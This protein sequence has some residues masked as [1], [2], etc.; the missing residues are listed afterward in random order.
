MPRGRHDHR[1]RDPTT[2]ARP[3][4]RRLGAGHT[5]LPR[6]LGALRPGLLLPGTRAHRRCRGGSP[7]HVGAVL[8]RVRRCLLQVRPARGPRDHGPPQRCPTP[9]YRRVPLLGHARCLM[10]LLALEARQNSFYYKSRYQQIVD[11][12]AD[13]MVLN[14]VGTGD[15]WPADR[16]RVAGSTHIDDLIAHA[17]AWHAEEHF[18][19]VLTFSESAV[20]A[21]ATV[22]AAL[23][24]PGIGVD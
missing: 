10:K 20:I 22:A 19:G 13:L 4:D 12:G 23:G 2:V 5:R 18:D 3:P 7:E 14:G 11:F 15:F 16:Y 17:A 6:R 24:L 8:R 21:T 9:G 1:P